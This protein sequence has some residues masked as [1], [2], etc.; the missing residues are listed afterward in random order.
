MR[1]LPV[2]VAS[3]AVRRERDLIAQRVGHVADAA[4]AL[5]VAL[6]LV[7]PF[8]GA[9]GHRQLV[10][11]RIA[12]QRAGVRERDREAEKER[13]TV[14]VVRPRLDHL[15]AEE[16][17]EL[18]ALQRE[19]L[20]VRWTVIGHGP[21]E[22]GLFDIEVIRFERVAVLDRAVPVPVRLDVAR[23]L[24]RVE[25]EAEAR[26]EPP[27]AG[28]RG[29]ELPEDGDPIV[30][31]LQRVQGDQTPRTWLV[32]VPGVRLSEAREEVDLRGALDRLLPGGDV[33]VR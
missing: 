10:R 2:T 19:A 9:A 20:Q 12:H 29:A 30:V 3:D 31:V 24:A 27:L 5:V 7:P 18:P 28:A 14:V 15:G 16:R 13:A 4:P 23:D 8:D 32:E 1:Y 26:D 25:L 11:D 17:H 6:D 22:V 33:F 21:R